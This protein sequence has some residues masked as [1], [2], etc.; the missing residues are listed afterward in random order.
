VRLLTRVSGSVYSQRQDMAIDF[1]KNANVLAYVHSFAKAKDKTPS[2]PYVVDGYELHAPPELVDRLKQLMAYTPEA[3]LQFAFG[4]PML[5][6]P[7]G[8]VFA[9]AG[10]TWYLC[11]YLPMNSTWGTAYAEYGN[12][13]RQGYASP[14]GR[15]NTEQHEAEMALLMRAAYSAAMQV[16]EHS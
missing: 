12:P 16:D 15:S 13:W 5:C 14:V 2:D 7:R 11:L 9:T 3:E 4:I 10:G 8:R 1:R 6:T